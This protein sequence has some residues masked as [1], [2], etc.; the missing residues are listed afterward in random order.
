MPRHA[1]PP[2]H[3]AA[4]PRAQHASG[5]AQARGTRVLRQFRQIFNVVKAHFQEVEKSAG[6]G[7]AHLW[8]L[9]LIEAQPG[10]GMNELAASMD[11]QQS[12]AS[13]LVRALTER[14]LVVTT[15]RTDD[16]RA[17]QLETL[18]AGRDVLARA[19]GPFTGVLPQALGAL[20]ARARAALERELAKLIAVLGADDGAAAVPLAQT[21]T[22]RRSAGR[23]G[24]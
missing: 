8:A 13:N 18:A 20:D 21:L 6:I 2:T 22:Q 3:A 24:S 7:G 16:K 11:I 1:S 10:I 4:E 23:K 9:S 15:R 17:V 12:T 19:P 14:R 5:D